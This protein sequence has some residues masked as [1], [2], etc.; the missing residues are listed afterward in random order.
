MPCTSNYTPVTDYGPICA[1]V[2]RTLDSDPLAFDVALL[3]LFSYPSIPDR[4]NAPR[5]SHLFKPS[6]PTG[7]SR[8]RRVRRLVSFPSHNQGAATIRTDGSG[9]MQGKQG[10]RGTVIGGLPQPTGRAE[11][12]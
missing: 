1:N 9:N 11:S 2:C 4:D 8:L 3:A 5:F 10:A 12:Y 6:L 7:V